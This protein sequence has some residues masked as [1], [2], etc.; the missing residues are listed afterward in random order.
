MFSVGLHWQ[1]IATLMND[2]AKGAETVEAVKYAIHERLYPIDA[3]DVTFI[4]N[5]FYSIM[6]R[7]T[8]GG[9]NLQFTCQ[10]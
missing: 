2:A 5:G 3:L 1:K 8:A 4:K 7:F 6:V 9:E 10:K